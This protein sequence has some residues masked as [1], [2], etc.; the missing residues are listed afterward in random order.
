MIGFI[1]DIMKKVKKGNKKPSKHKTQSV[2]NKVKTAGKVKDNLPAITEK[3]SASDPKGRLVSFT[4]GDGEIIVEKIDLGIKEVFAI[5]DES[6]AIEKF[7]FLRHCS[8]NQ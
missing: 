7:E 8:Q 2:V 3:V 4:I 5:A 1:K 6:K